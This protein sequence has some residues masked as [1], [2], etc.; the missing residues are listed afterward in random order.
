LRIAE[1]LRPDIRWEVSKVQAN[2]ILKEGMD[3]VSAG[4]FSMPVIMK[5]V[6]GTVS[7]G[8]TY[9]SAYDGAGG[10]LLGVKE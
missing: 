9:G 7:A 1:G 6:T 4:D 10:E 3:G 2:A 8:E 5:I